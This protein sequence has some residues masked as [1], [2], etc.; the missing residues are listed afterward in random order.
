M[1]ALTLLRNKLNSEKSLA[2]A[3][4]LVCTHITAQSAVLIETLVACGAVVR[5]C[6]CNI[7]STQNEV[8]AAIAEVIWGVSGGEIWVEVVGF[9]ILH[10]IDWN[11]YCSFS[12]V[13]TMDYMILVNW[14]LLQE[15]KFL[16]KV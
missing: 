9:N 1:S 12:H 13:H 11:Q 7:H 6:S 10:I 2:G 3:R 8:A 15:S 5:V 16:T 14:S 4:I